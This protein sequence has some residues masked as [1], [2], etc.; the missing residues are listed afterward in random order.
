[1]TRHQSREERV[2]EI[3]DAAA[4][5]IDER[6]LPA[7]TMDAVAARTSLSKGGVYRFFRNKADV[8]AALVD[9]ILGRWSRIDVEAALARGLPADETLLALILPADGSSD[10]PGSRDRRVWLQLLP[11]SLRD[12]EL[13]R[14]RIKHQEEAFKRYE[15][16]AFELV[17]R[18][19]AGG[20]S[21]GG[22]SLPGGEEERARDEDE[23]LSGWLRNQLGLGLIFGAGV[24]MLAAVGEPPVLLRDALRRFLQTLISEAPGRWSNESP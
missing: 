14:I 22:G 23:S 2:R 12:P 24:T 4:A 7:L 6:G 10:S 19:R 3:L 11:E 18:D 15:E 16:L 9:D 21:A 8:I 17:K 1:M 13:V 20:G 5:E